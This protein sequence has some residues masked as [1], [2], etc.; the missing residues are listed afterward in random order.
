[1]EKLKK[2]FFN[3]DYLYKPGEKI[4]L[5]GFFFLPS[6]PS[7]GFALLFISLI[8]S[9]FSK[10]YINFKDR[11]NMPIFASIGIILFNTLYIS[12][13]NKPNELINFPVSIIWVNLFNWIPFLIG[14]IWFQEYLNTRD[15]RANLVKFIV[16]G[17][18]PVI[19][20]CFIQYLFNWTGPKEIFNG[21]IVW[22]LKPIEVSGGISG[23]F[24]NTNYAGLWLVTI[25]PLIFFL[26]HINHNKGEYYKKLFSIIMA[27]LNV[28]LI[29]QTNSRN[30]FL[31]LF[32]SLN[33]IL[34]IKK[35]LLVSFTILILFLFLK[36]SSISLISFEIINTIIPENL[37]DKL[38]NIKIN[39]YS[40][41][42]LIWAST[43]SLIISRPIFGWGSGTFS[44]LHINSSKNWHPPLIKID[45][46]HSHNLFFELSHNFG[47]PLSLILCTTFLYLLFKSIRKIY[48]FD[49]NAKNSIIN[50]YWLVSTTIII[51]C[52][53]TDITY[54]DGRI[55]LL[56]C[57]L[58]S[59][60]R[61]ILNNYENPIKNT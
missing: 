31:G 10:P 32:I 37:I 29:F 42:I 38:T 33:F 7:L 46:T 6:I 14:F 18:M 39:L 11:W 19:F 1:M 45:A 58:L 48:Q 53:L 12:F 55:G 51:F 25:L 21:F 2:I 22:F 17:S 50:K 27:L 56:F 40:P 4:F 52:H 34:G 24:S 5:L 30:A 54:Y 16:S 9:I 41:R 49:H 59:G 3:F 26:I 44:S 36:Y 15:K 20:S 8:F 23:L 28:F 13:I 35:M 61:C 43:L 57:I 47:L 60:T